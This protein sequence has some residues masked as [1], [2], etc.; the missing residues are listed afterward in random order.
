MCMCVCGCGGGGGGGAFQQMQRGDTLQVNLIDSH[1]SD[2]DTGGTRCTV[3]VLVM[4][5]LMLCVSDVKRRGETVCVA[6]VL[7]VCVCVCQQLHSVC[8]EH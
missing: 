2:G 4:S 7:Y 1:M 5:L 6:C 8:E 3:E